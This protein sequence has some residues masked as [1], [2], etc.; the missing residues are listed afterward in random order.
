MSILINETTNFL[1]QGIT[2]KQG[3]RACQEMKS[4]GAKVTCG[5]TPGKGGQEIEGVPVYNT[6]E[7]ARQKHPI[8]ASVLYIPPKL[9]KEAIIEAIT[10]GIPL[11]NVVTENIPLHDMAYCLALAKEKNVRIVGATSAGIYSVGRVKCGSIAGGKSKIAFSPGK[12][13]VMS[14]SGGMACET[15]LV[16]TQAGLGQSTVISLGSDVLMGSTYLDLLPDFELDIETDG[17]VI[18]GEIGGTSEEDLAA[19]LMTR[20][21]EGNPFPKPIIAFISGLFTEKYKFENVSLGHAGAI[22]D[23][24]KGT[25]ANKVRALNEAGVIIAGKHHDLGNLMKEA[26]ARKAQNST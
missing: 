11:L 10:A 2:G 24:E 15:S 25:R 3:T 6:V 5:V 23:G 16:L 14:R 17:I 9:A 21:K 22:I 20:R 13:G 7:E 12:I 4:I 19:Y 18:F 1:I 8:D 26:L